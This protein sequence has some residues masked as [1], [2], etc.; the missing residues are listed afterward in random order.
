M[1]SFILFSPNHLLIKESK[2]KNKIVTVCLANVFHWAQSNTSLS[3][4]FNIPSEQMQRPR[5]ISGVAASPLISLNKTF[6]GAFPL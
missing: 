4:T 2:Q 3:I 5:D 6:H 1:N